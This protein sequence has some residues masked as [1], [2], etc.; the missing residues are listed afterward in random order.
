MVPKTQTR[1]LA[2]VRIPNRE[3]L[4]LFAL[5]YP[6]GWRVQARLREQ[7]LCS[8]KLT[9]LRVRD[10]LKKE[11]Q[12]DIFNYKLFNFWHNLKSN[13]TNYFFRN[14]IM[15]Y[16]KLH[17][18]NNKTDFFL[19]SQSRPR[20]SNQESVNSRNVCGISCLYKFTKVLFTTNNPNSQWAASSWLL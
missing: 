8:K 2:L 10:L 13:E 5:S 19:N 4:S 7:V 12:I 9:F 3:R 20:T 14:L 11:V 17:K 6:P 1:K 18:A 16:H 15:S